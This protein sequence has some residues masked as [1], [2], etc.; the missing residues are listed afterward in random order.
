MQFRISLALTN[1]FLEKTGRDTYT[2][3]PEEDMESC[4][5]HMTIEGYNVLLEFFTETINI[6]YFLSAQIWQ[7]ETDNTIS[8][9]TQTSAN[10]A[11]LI[12]KSSSM[13][14][15]I[16]R[17]QSET[18]RKGNI[19]HHTLKESLIN[20]HIL[21]EEFKQSTDEQRSLIFE[22]FDRYVKL[23]RIWH[24]TIQ[25]TPFKS[26]LFFFT[27][28]VSY[29]RLYMEKLQDF[30]PFHITAFH[31][32]SAI[33][34]Q[35]LKDLRMPVKSLQSSLTANLKKKQHNICDACMRV[36]NANHPRLYHP[37]LPIF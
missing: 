18:V 11:N 22:I 37:Q 28:L 36:G 32:S 35:I 8:F 5:T 17:K 26:C 14:K 3:P 10:V 30:I 13:Q 12:K 15:A 6:C 33:F 29:N 27:E 24:V 1:C 21:Y 16:L 4:T 20:A 2:C 23:L 34:S 19:L 25:I 31:L 7:Q 9:L